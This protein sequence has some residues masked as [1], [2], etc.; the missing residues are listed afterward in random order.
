MDVRC[1]LLERIGD[2]QTDQA[3][4]RR[5]RGQ[6]LQL[7]DVGEHPVFVDDARFDA[8][9]NLAER[10]LVAAVHPLECRL[11][12]VRQRQHRPDRSPGHHREG[13]DREL[14]GRID[15]RQRQLA[16]V[17]LDR[18]RA[19]LTKKARA[20]T[21]FEYRKFGVGSRFD[22]LQS[23]LLRQCFADFALRDETER[24]Q[25]LAQSLTLAAGVGIALLQPEGSLERN[26][27]ELAALDEQLSQA[28][29]NDGHRRGD[30][31]VLGRHRRRIVG[32]WHALGR[33][34]RRFGR[35]HRGARQVKRVRRVRCVGPPSADHARH[36]QRQCRLIGRRISGFQHPVSLL[37]GALSC[38]N[39]LGGPG[40]HSNPSN[41]R[42]AAA[43]VS[44]I[45]A[46]E[47]A[48]DTKPASK[49]DGAR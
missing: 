27:V 4:N 1:A 18:Q 6:V 22:H 48:A 11:E 42:L 24:N 5:L 16:L 47:C 36:R 44:S 39:D 13:I 41:A 43:I 32:N 8:V 19:R 37:P 35:D 12:L 45:S 40:C 14:I 26:G 38:I 17:F 31:R 10:R 15:H 29:P 25:Q 46:F 23:E 3:D 21:L 49:A 20:H 7:L 34:R 30:R 33:R 28:T 2:H 9:D